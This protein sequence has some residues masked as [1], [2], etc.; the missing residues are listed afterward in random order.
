MSCPPP[1]SNISLTCCADW[2]PDSRS[3]TREDSERQ[4]RFPAQDTPNS[5]AFRIRESC[6][7]DRWTRV[8][9]FGFR[10]VVRRFRVSVLVTRRFTRRGPVWRCADRVQIDAARSRR[11]DSLWLSPPC[12]IDRSPLPLDWPSQILDDSERD[13]RLM[14]EPRPKLGRPLPLSSGPGD[15]TWAGPQDAGRLSALFSVVGAVGR[16]RSRIRPAV[17]R[18]DGRDQAQ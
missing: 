9:F 8:F 18:P 4:F 11:C 16:R 10:H 6:V 14:R 2:R 7:G 1:R 3:F 13:R 15:G 12:L 17:G 5:L